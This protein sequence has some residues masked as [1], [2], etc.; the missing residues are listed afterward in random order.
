MIKY[1]A[2]FVLGFS[3][4]QLIVGLMNWVYGV[5]LKEK[6][7]ST[8][9]K[10]ISILI[11]A[12][13][14]E[15]NIGSLLS[16]LIQ[17]GDNIIEIIV[18]DD[19]STDKTAEIVEEYSIKDKRIKLIKSQGL[20]EGW[21]G[22]NFACHKL[23]LLAKGD[24]LLFLDSDV[25]I[26]NKVIERSLDY[27]IREK[28]D[29]LSI[30]PFQNMLSFGEKISIPNMNFILLSLLPLPLVSLSKFPSLA[31]AN[32]QFM[33]FDN[34]TY[35]EIEPHKLFKNSKAEDIEISRHYKKL[36]KNI[37]CLASVKDVSCRMYNG[38]PDA[39]QG[40][41]KNVNYFFGNSYILAILFWIITTFG[42]ILVLLVQ[43]LDLFLIYIITIILT[44]IY[45]SLTSNQN[46]LENILYI[47]PQQV[48]LGIIIYKSIFNKRNKQFKWK[49][50]MI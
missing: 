14:E 2:F 13:N 3:F 29:F 28:L 35:K 43:S 40:F 4:L 37:N 42:I 34:N 16:D 32:G 18:F 8:L 1:I 45:I 49:D 25:R 6:S 46:I 41:S 22:K 10:A 12:R 20:D 23:S 24:Y 21:L 47:I 19:E 31:A 5:R 9:K 11:P 36:G 44:R 7:S 39:I 50:R 27:V 48:I 17:T 30:F 38:L 26:K 33:L 15:Y